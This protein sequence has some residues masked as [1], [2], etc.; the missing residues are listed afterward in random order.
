MIQYTEFSR[1]DLHSNYYFFLE[2]T[3]GDS[4]SL[5]VQAH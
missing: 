2:K 1:V 3:E 4:N 5:E